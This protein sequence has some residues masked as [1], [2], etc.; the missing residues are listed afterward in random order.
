MSAS[1][2]LWKLRNLD[3]RVNFRIA[4][5]MFGKRV[6]SLDDIKNFAQWEKA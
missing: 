6:A 4:F 2:C 1:F 5:K 3:I